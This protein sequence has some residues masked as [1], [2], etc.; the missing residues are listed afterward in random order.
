MRFR[1]ARF[2]LAIKNSRGYYDA[3]RQKVKISIQLLLHY[4]SYEE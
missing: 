1:I 2:D 3:D 4:Y